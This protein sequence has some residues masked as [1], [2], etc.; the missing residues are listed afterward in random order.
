[1]ENLRTASPTR[2]D[3]DQYFPTGAGLTQKKCWDVGLKNI[4]W[5]LNAVLVFLVNFLN[6]QMIRKERGMSSNNIHVSQIQPK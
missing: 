1:M 3:Q 2:K 4:C 5:A 6:P